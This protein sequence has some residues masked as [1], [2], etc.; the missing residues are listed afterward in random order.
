MFFTGATPETGTSSESETAIASKLHSIGKEMTSIDTQIEEL[1]QKKQQLILQRQRQKENEKQTQQEYE[2]SRKREQ[3]QKETS[4]Q[5]EIRLQKMRD[6]SAKRRGTNESPEQREARLKKMREYKA[7]RK[8]KE[9]IN[10]PGGRKDKKSEKESG[11]CY[12]QE[13]DTALKRE[14][15]KRETSEQRE[16][17]LQK[18]R[19]YSASRREKLKNAGPVQGKSYEL[20][21][22]G[23]YTARER[24]RTRERVAAIRANKSE[25]EK[26]QENEAARERMAKLRSARTL[27]G[28]GDSSRRRD[29]AY[30]CAERKDAKHHEERCQVRKWRLKM[31]NGGEDAGPEPMHYS[32]LSPNGRL[33]TCHDCDQDLDLPLA[34]S[35]RCWKSFD[36]YD[37]AELFGKVEEYNRTHQE[38]R[39]AIKREIKA[40][41]EMRN[42]KTLRTDEE[43]VTK[44]NGCIGSATCV[45]Q[46]GGEQDCLKYI[47]KK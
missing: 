33:V 16:V 2:R 8:L 13:Y 38:R 25:E 10:A 20:P 21:K 24:E 39:D 22:S 30:R 3:R 15:R 29:E 12:T 35:A 41:E 40:N 42:E 32:A 31:A 5:R 14:Q 6:Y 44:H 9:D 11:Y 23:K 19:E 7:A 47:P 1:I 17:R 18:M 27:A 36:C 46:S 26:F 45:F 28:E 43:G 34:G 4:E 37:C